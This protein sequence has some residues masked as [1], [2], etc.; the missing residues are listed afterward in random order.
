M[1]ILPAALSPLS[2]F[3]RDPKYSVEKISLS[4]VPYKILSCHHKPDEYKTYPKPEKEVSIY[5]ELS[6]S[7]AN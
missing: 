3:D 5:G 2:F 6:V 1:F 7:R 4:Y